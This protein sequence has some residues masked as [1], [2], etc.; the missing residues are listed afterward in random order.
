MATTKDEILQN[1]F[2]AEKRAN[3]P[4]P[5]TENQAAADNNAP[6][7]QVI[8]PQP[9][10]TTAESKGLQELK[11]G[12]S[13]DEDENSL[14]K[15]MAQRDAGTLTPTGQK[16]AEDETTPH[17]PGYFTKKFLES[18][19]KGKPETQEER[20]DREKRERRNKMWAAIGDGI[21][22]L[23]NMVATSRGAK[24]SFDPSKGLSATMRQ[25]YDQ[26]NKEREAN[27]RAWNAAYERAQKQDNDWKKF[28]DTQ[29]SKEEKDRLDREEK[30]AKRKSIEEKNQ[31]KK[32][33]LLKQQEALSKEDYYTAAYWEGI[34]KHDMTDE[35]ARN[36]A[37]SQVSIKENRARLKTSK[38]GRKKGRAA[39]GDASPVTTETR[40]AEG[41]LVKTVTK[42]K[43]KPQTNQGGGKSLLPQPQSKGQKGTLLPK[44]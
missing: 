23:A 28:V 3:Y 32:D 24:N 2:E 27:E 36:Y 1:Q 9:T 10:M 35:E 4:D 12:L 15:K 25:R 20:E 11:D 7:Q 40:D 19:M 38:G 13:K 29:K 34:W 41:N 31:L 33:A 44:K 16:P 18:G 39:A 30:A 14:T 26:L 8:Q 43:G 17:Q 42:Y 5:G 37:A 6:Q 22:A 21:A